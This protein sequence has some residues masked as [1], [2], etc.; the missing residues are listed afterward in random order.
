M[1]LKKA[2]NLENNFKYFICSFNN[3]EFSI[4]YNCRI[5]NDNYKEIFCG[6]F[7]E[8]EKNIF[9]DIINDNKFAILYKNHEN[10]KI[11]ELALFKIDNSNKNIIDGTKIP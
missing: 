2:F 7:N 11:K 5:I 10:E 8:N 4:N 6:L 3:Q 9:I 1:L